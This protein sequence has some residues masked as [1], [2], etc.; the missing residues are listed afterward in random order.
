MIIGEVHGLAKREENDLAA[1][2]LAK[3]VKSYI[4]LNSPLR[5]D[6][7]VIQFNRAEKAILEETPE[8]ETN[9]WGVRIESI[10]KE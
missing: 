7:I 4:I 9:Y 3:K 8:E 6:D 5:E 1:Y 2:E 10:I